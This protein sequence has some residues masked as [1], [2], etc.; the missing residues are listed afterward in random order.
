M[1]VG[2]RV[3]GASRGKHQGVG[4]MLGGGSHT[5]KRQQMGEQSRKTVAW[6]VGEMQGEVHRRGSEQQ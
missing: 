1:E 5:E 6:S 3:E 2:E 4:N